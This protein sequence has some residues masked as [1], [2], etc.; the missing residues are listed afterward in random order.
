[1]VNQGIGVE[2]P[3]VE[4]QIPREREP[5]VVLANRHQEADEL[6]QRIWRNDMETNN[7]LTTMVE[8]IMAQNGVDVGLHRP[9]YTSPLS[10]YVL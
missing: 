2:P 5:R 7:N 4:Q 1:M 9:N 10:E 6:I 8:R 3:R